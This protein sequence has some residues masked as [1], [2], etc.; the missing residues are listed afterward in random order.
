[1]N[2]GT[3]AR[4]GTPEWTPQRG[5]TANRARGGCPRKSK[6][7]NPNPAMERGEVWEAPP[8][9]SS[10]LRPRIFARRW[11]IGALRFGSWEFIGILAACG[12]HPRY[13]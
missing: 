7:P 8:A 6:I 10:D 5:S 4:D 3:A 12:P 9:T 2:G 11:G 13:D 1:M